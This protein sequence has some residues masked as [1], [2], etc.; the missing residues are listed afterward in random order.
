MQFCRRVLCQP[1]SARVTSPGEDMEYRMGGCIGISHR[2]AE[3]HAE[4]LSQRD[5]ELLLTASSS[6][7]QSLL[8][9]PVLP[10]VPVITGVEESRGA[11]EEAHEDKEELEFP[12]D[13][14]PN[15]DFSSELNIWESSL[16]LKTRVCE[17]ENAL[18]AGL[19]HH[20]EVSHPLVV[21]D[22]RPQTSD[23]LLTAAPPSPQPTATP[24]PDGQPLTPPLC[25]LLDQELQEA[26]QE[27]EEQMV[28]LG[29]PQHKEPIST[30]SETSN[31]EHRKTGNATVKKY[32]ESSSQ[33]QVGDQS[34]HSN[35]INKNTHGNTETADRQ[36]DTVVFSFR[37]YILGTDNPETDCDT[38]K[39]NADQE[40]NPQAETVET[41]KEEPQN[42]KITNTLETAMT[43]DAVFS[44]GHDL[45]ADFNAEEIDR[46]KND[47][48]QQL[49][50]SSGLYFENKS[51][52]EILSEQQTGT[53]SH[54]EDDTQTTSA[55]G[56]ELV[57]N[58]RA[59]KRDKKKNRKKKKAEKNKEPEAEGR[60]VKQAENE[61]L[62]KT[63][64][65]S[66]VSDTM[67]GVSQPCDVFLDNTS[68]PS[69]PS[70]HHLACSSI[71]NYVPTHLNQFDNQNVT[72]NIP[73]KE[74]DT[75]A[76]DDNV[77]T[78][79]QIHKLDS[80]FSNIHARVGESCT[81]RAIE[82]AFVEAAALPLTTPTMREV[83]KSEGEI[84]SH[85]SLEGVAAESV[86][87]IGKGQ[88]ETDL[89]GIKSRKILDSTSE[90]S[91]VC[92]SLGVSNEDT[93][94][95]SEES[96]DS[97]M[98]H[99]SAAE[100]CSKGQRETSNAEA[101][102]SPAEEGDKDK[103][104]LWI[105]SNFNNSPHG[106]LT[107]ADHLNDSAA[108]VDGGGVAERSS[109]SL[110]EGAARGV[111]AAETEMH[112][113]TD[114]AESCLKSPYR[115]ET[116][117]TVTES[118][119]TEEEL[120][121]AFLPRPPHSEQSNK[122][123][124]ESVQHNLNSKEPLS[125][126]SSCEESAITETS[127]TSDINNQQVHPESITE[128]ADE[129]SVI[130]RVGK[131]T[132]DKSGTSNRVRFADNVKE[133]RSAIVKVRNMSMPALGCASLP[134]LTVHERLHHPVVEASY[135]FRDYLSLKNPETCTEVTS[136]KNET[137]NQSLEDAP[138][139][140]KTIP[141]DVE[142]TQNV[143]IKP[144]G[145]DNSK[146][147]EKNPTNT[148]HGGLLE[149]AI[150]PTEPAKNTEE[151]VE[152]P[153]NEVAFVEPTQMAASEQSDMTTEHQEPEKNPD[154]VST[155]YEEKVTQKCDLSMDIIE[156]SEPNNP[157]VI[158]RDICV[159]SEIESSSS[160]P[161]VGDV[162]CEPIDDVFTESP[163]KQFS[164]ETGTLTSPVSSQ[165]KPRDLSCQPPTELDKLPSHAVSTDPIESRKETPVELINDES[166]TSEVEAA[167][168][169][170]PVPVSAS[171]PPLMLHPP[172]PMLSHL[173]V[174]DE[175]DVALPD[176]DDSFG[177]KTHTP[178]YSAEDPR[179]NND[180]TK[181][182][183]SM[184]ADVFITSL[185]SDDTITISHGAECVP[186]NN[187]L[188]DI[189]TQD[190]NMPSNEICETIEIC[191]I[192]YN[193][194]MDKE[195][196][197]SLSDKD[198]QLDIEKETEDSSKLQTGNAPT[199]PSKESDKD[200]EKETQ[201]YEL[202]DMSMQHINKTLTEA[203]ESKDNRDASMDSYSNIE[204]SIGAHREQQQEQ[205]LG[206]GSST[207]GLT[208]DRVETFEEE[209]KMSSHGKAASAMIELV[210]KDCGSLETSEGQTLLA[211][212]DSE[213]TT[214]KV[215]SLEKVEKEKVIPGVDKIDV[216]GGTI[217]QCVFGKTGMTLQQ[218]VSDNKNC[219]FAGNDLMH[220]HE[221]LNCLGSKGQPESN[222]SDSSADLTANHL[223][224]RENTVPE[225]S[226]SEDYD[227]L[228]LGFSILTKLATDSHSIHTDSCPSVN[229]DGKMLD[230]TYS[231]V[232]T[233]HSA[234]QTG[235]THNSE[236]EG[237]KIPDAVC[238]SLELQCSN[239]SSAAQSGPV[240]QTAI[241]GPHV[242]EIAGGNNATIDEENDGFQAAR[243][244][245][246]KAIDSKAMDEDELPKD[247]DPGSTDVSHQSESTTETAA[248]PSDN[249]IILLKNMENDSTNQPQPNTGCSL[250]YSHMSENSTF[251]RTTQEQHTN[252]IQALREATS[253]PQSEQERIH[254]NR[255]LP[256][257]ESP[258]EFVTPTEEVA[259]PLGQEQITQEYNA[260]TT[261]QP[262]ADLAEFQKFK[263]KTQESIEEH[264]VPKISPVIAVHQAESE[265]PVKI[266]DEPSD[267]IQNKIE[268]SEPTT[269]ALSDEAQRATE[270]LE[271]EK[272]TNT[273]HP[274]EKPEENPTEEN[275]GQDPSEVLQEIG[276]PL[277][278]HQERS[279]AFPLTSPI[280]HPQPA[281]HPDLS[282]PPPPSPEKTPPASP[283]FPPLPA[284]PSVPSL[285]QQE[286]H[287]P[288]PG[289]LCHLLLRSSDSDGAFET[290]ES[291][292]PVKA[293]AD[294]QSQLPT[295]DDKV[296]DITLK[297]SSSGLTSDLLS[298][299]TSTVFDEDR[300]IAASGAYN[301][302][303]FASES[304][305]QPLTRSLSLQGEELDTTGLSDGSVTKGFRPHSESFSVGTESAPGTLRRPKK[306]RTGSV[307]KKPLLRQNSNPERPSST[308]STPEL[309]KRPKPQTVTQE[310]EEG[311]SITTSPTGTLRKTRKIPVDTPPP[312]PEENNHT[313]PEKS[314]EAPALPLCQEEN[315]LS[316][317][318]PIT[319]DLP[320][321]PRASYK[322]DPDNFDCIDP[323]KTG[324]SKIANSPVLGRKAPVCVLNA[325]PPESPP[326][327]AVKEPP[328]AA[329]TE[330]LPFNPEEQP[331][332]PKRES[333]RLEFDYT[334]DNCEASQTAS[335][336]LKKVGKKPGAKMPLRKP[337]LGLKKAHLAQIEQLDNDLP[338]TLNGN[339]EEI[340]ISKGSYHFESD[341]W[342]DPNFNPFST[343]AHI[344]N[345]P[346]ATDPAYSFDFD[347]SIDPFKSTNKMANSPPRASSS[348][349]SSNEDVENDDNIGELEDQNQN[350]P[351]KKKKT[352]IKSNTFR[353]KRSPKKSPLSDPSQDTDD[354]A[355]FHPQ[356]DHATDEEK[357]AS[358][359]SHKWAGLS[360]DQQDFPQPSDLTSFVESSLQPSDYEIEY[361][362]KIGSSS[363]PLSVRKPSLYLKLDSLSDNIN[364]D[365]H[366]PNSPCTGS[367][368]EME[369]QITAGMK[370]PIL[371]SR[372]GPEG[373]AGEK[374]RK[375]ESEVLSRT[376][377]T[378][379]DEQLNSQE[380]PASVPTMPLLDRLSECGDPVQYLE[381]D[382]A[383]TN[384]NAFAQKLQEELVL[385]ALRIEAL[386]IA[387]N[388]S[389]CPSL[390]NVTP[391][392]RLKKPTT[393]RW[394]IN[395]S[396]LLK[397]RD[398]SSPSE[399]AVSKNTLY[400]RTATS[401]MDGESPHLPKDLDHSLGIAREEI[402]TKERE[403]LEW[404]KKYEDSRQEV[405]E[406]RRIVAE[407]EKTIAQM[408]EDD[409][410]E[411]S[412][413][414]HTIQQLIVEKDQ[415][416]ADLNSVEK[417]LAD[418]FRRYEKMKDVLEGFRKNE[419][420]LKKCAQEYLSRV[421]KEEQRYQALKIHAEEK[422]DKANSEIAQVRAKSK[423]EQAAHQAS[424]RKEQ[425]KV[426]SLER[427][428]EQKNKEIEELTKICDELISKMGKC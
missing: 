101:E 39:T 243:T 373:S 413:S 70:Q 289:P 321:P 27:C 182:A 298:H 192:K 368:E 276:A 152:L 370:T 354:P 402:V 309:I 291:T 386:Q 260:I 275:T 48:I 107:A 299:S 41:I 172:G 218:R 228:P 251:G 17:H 121:A 55:Q 241:K 240:T 128:K 418:L 138:K 256:S 203:I 174:V 183:D 181:Q 343:K 313:E 162:P 40:K 83:I 301:F 71:F 125:L 232:K 163:D 375:R 239:K 287:D 18:L 387:K 238:E 205:I 411:K 210:D 64:N 53:K 118:L 428:L 177:N 405:A 195:T 302:E 105:E 201:E 165:T 93:K 20:M 173:E 331:I 348:F 22:N 45:S 96:C 43:G 247:A 426:D 408:I 376:Q 122:A 184:D 1:C 319:E 99:T 233:D 246:I 146:P 318:P 377:S 178:T 285:P 34:G 297:D 61:L 24:H 366:E 46:K 176:C 269:K 167:E 9:Q 244:R 409:Q 124:G 155:K 248:C 327:S 58:K 323:F 265:E 367:F 390:S 104:T 50:E 110:P 69:P 208:C 333:V 38:I 73:D 383:E 284:C 161:A 13:L 391:Q 148:E 132:C 283:H 51:V 425:M 116:V 356:D 175:C 154:E 157:E 404:Q 258:R 115:G 307:K 54:I 242:E 11:A 37:D 264:P 171:N 338:A 166:V 63:G 94:A 393:R 130:H 23:K 91:S 330:E 314:L 292:T 65:H 5:A 342:E 245:E 190:K 170:I 77:T 16:G 325:S 144:S 231:T 159:V 332:L 288:N 193:Q 410:K 29:I 225:E 108:E 337:K 120:T 296:K 135:I 14:L 42:Q 31:E 79:A 60:T 111:S 88:T 320:I 236:T 204:L 281:P 279:S 315:H 360:S 92:G 196:S 168:Q 8:S 317:S 209:G 179:E 237:C 380:A 257:L 6:S 271:P 145:E 211:S 252:W 12:H 142:D 359:T 311:S 341:K 305:S 25:V 207:D 250:E 117:I 216:P 26:F 316:S 280:L 379:R 89:E 214:E 119:C 421:R 100:S 263:E 378:E 312:L 374:G 219:E 86:A 206:V 423:Q 396:P 286:D 295:I 294:L 392:S 427:T 133:D 36:M 253:D 290:P 223:A 30:E 127:M 7:Q 352:P 10:D 381:P 334:E 398:V 329:P 339:E 90:L 2:Q 114:V 198:I 262:E 76:L 66:E 32:D 412:L 415:A 355:S 336:P 414:H 300:P 326:I 403:V 399:T 230:K 68:L 185:P 268:F 143:D 335:P 274:E 200:A 308:S 188:N 394:N 278:E 102:I 363:P 169:S 134:P 106:I 186:T 350:K 424:L 95:L 344:S 353:V 3:A 345:S 221:F 44:E 422:L 19:Q 364:K 372:P 149:K 358:T 75:Q 395:G 254:I 420:V 4:K 67:T 57:H 82:D 229:Q 369:A 361:M 293:P 371:S 328:P 113:P 340:P 406:M 400:T 72:T 324:G 194:N 85:D 98:P 49:S 362:E 212:G 80:S 347:D 213:C 234:A 56:G 384:P 87:G 136:I 222:Q 153:N 84:V 189:T 267:L 217:G 112:P 365:I 97:K 306:V 416:L 215:E 191:S 417:S 33:P 226:F 407:Y 255:P 273:E 357:L 123:D 349:E 389:Q 129:I 160:V 151:P 303:H 62:I 137:P 220:D 266:K 382:L 103:E 227:I 156:P 385:A 35:L 401:Y 28:L 346:K 109:F 59:K 78:E 141:L 304:P 21:L 388:I 158:K 81:E 147:T 139:P 259:A 277:T 202:H 272:K 197:M 52:E 47:S 187:V 150:A 282:T 180:G 397:H 140:E 270:H 74:S 164:T 351:A 126:G 131:S 261:L 322:W 15:L 235:K 310:V 224:F 249:N 419:E 199:Q